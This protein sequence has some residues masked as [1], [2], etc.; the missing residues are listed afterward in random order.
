MERTLSIIKPDAVERNL[1]NKIKS[2]FEDKNLKV[3]KSKSLNKSKI[4]GNFFGW[5]SLDEQKKISKIEF[6][7]KDQ[8]SEHL[9]TQNPETKQSLEVEAT[10]P[11]QNVY[12]PHEDLERKNKLKAMQKKGR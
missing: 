9:T 7:T 1:E 12:P 3:L 2:F 6:R 8:L 4:A 5:L 10:N 11:E